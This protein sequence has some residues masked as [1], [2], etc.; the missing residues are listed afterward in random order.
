MEDVRLFTDWTCSS[1]KGH[2]M[3]FFFCG[4][5]LFCVSVS[6]KGFLAGHADGRVVRYFFDSEGS[7]ESQVLADHHSQTYIQE[8]CLK[9]SAGGLFVPV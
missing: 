7:R 8:K 4:F 6:G 5:C 1:S 3:G 2:L 9:T